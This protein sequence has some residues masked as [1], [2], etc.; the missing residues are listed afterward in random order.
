MTL[1]HFDEDGRAHMVDVGDKPASDRRARAEATV[2][3]GR[4]LLAAVLDRGITKGDVL[5][6]ARLAGIAAVKRTPD[7]VPLA[8]PLTLHHVAV[9]LEPDR[10]A[11]TLLVSCQVRAVER[12]GVEMEALTGAAAAALTVYD[13]CK[14][15]DRGITITDL[16]VVEKSGGRSGRWSRGE[17][18]T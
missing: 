13:M 2:R 16:R 9:D 15:A 8:H 5:G 18:T 4:D 1:N 12:T 3:L 14:A 17:V 6:T 11:G 10:D 7:L